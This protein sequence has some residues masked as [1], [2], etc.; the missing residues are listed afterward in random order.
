MGKGVAKAQR[1]ELV[2]LA[3]DW[4]EGHGLALEE[5][6][7][8]KDRPDGIDNVVQ[9]EAS[10]RLYVSKWRL[11]SEDGTT[12]VDM[13]LRAKPWLSIVMHTLLLLGL[14][15]LLYLISRVLWEYTLIN[16]LSFM[17]VAFLVMLLFWWRDSRLLRR[18]SRLE[19]SFW[20]TVKLRY[21]T[22][23]L[24]RVGIPVYTGKFR[25][26]QQVTLTGWAVLVGWIVLGLAIPVCVQYPADESPQAHGGCTQRHRLL[27]EHP[28]HIC[29]GVS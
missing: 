20:E 28:N 15:I 9:Y 12:T 13:T 10:G 5:S 21:D 17:G 19:S 23:Q 24:T 26:I 3:Q 25:L 11:H 8:S 4:A 2:A 14:G 16:I 27:F 6:S 22:Q 29:F 18:M 7:P 1:A